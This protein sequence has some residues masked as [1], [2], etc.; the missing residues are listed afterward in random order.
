M[1]LLWV[2]VYGVRKECSHHYFSCWCP[3]FPTP[4]MEES[5]F[6]YCI[7]SSVPVPTLFQ[8]L[9]FW[10]IVGSFSNKHW[11]ILHVFS[12]LIVHLFSS[13]TEIQLLNILQTIFP[14][15]NEGCLGGFQ[16]LRLWINIIKTSVCRLF[17]GYKLSTHLD[18]YKRARLMN[19]LVRGCLVL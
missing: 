6:P 8:L 14:F 16:F 12:D 17:C 10:S 18:K 4:F 9:H 19:H 3:V 11:R 2:C 15:T 5:F 7:A 13:L 1:N